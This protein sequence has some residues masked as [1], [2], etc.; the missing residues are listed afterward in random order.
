MCLHQCITGELVGCNN[1][2]QLG[3]GICNCDA[4]YFGDACQFQRISKSFPR[5]QTRPFVWHCCQNYTILFREVVTTITVTFSQI[6]IAPIF[7]MAKHVL[8][9][10]AHAYTDYGEPTVTKALTLANAIL[11]GVA[12]FA[13]FHFVVCMGGSDAQTE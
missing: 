5:L 3:N 9:D 2:G 1:H 7:Q 12:C 10:N 6:S 11:G 8:L 4:T 13:P